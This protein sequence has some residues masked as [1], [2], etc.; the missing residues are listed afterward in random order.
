[1]YRCSNNES[2]ATQSSSRN[3]EAIVSD[4][5]ILKA[6]ILIFYISIN[7]YCD[8]P[9]LFLQKQTADFYKEAKIYK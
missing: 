6:G 4:S 8:D 7:I 9:Y 3:F 1:M 5:A 2:T